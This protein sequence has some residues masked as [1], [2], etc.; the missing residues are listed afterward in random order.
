M[1]FEAQHSKIRF[2]SNFRQNLPK[3]WPYM[4]YFADTV[5]Q[6]QQKMFWYL[7]KLLRILGLMKTMFFVKKTSGW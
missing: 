4:Y 1:Y 2:Q 3:C 6:K 5:R 7:R